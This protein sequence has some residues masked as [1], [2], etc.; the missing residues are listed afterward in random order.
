ME[1]GIS[2][3]KIN[4]LTSLC[5]KN[6]NDFTLDEINEIHEQGK[7]ITFQDVIS[8][9]E[10]L[11][12]HGDIA[13]SFGEDAEEKLVGIVASLYTCDQI[14]DLLSGISY[15]SDIPKFVNFRIEK[16]VEPDYVI[17]YDRLLRLCIDDNKP[18]EILA[19]YNYAYEKLD[20]KIKK[21][22]FEYVYSLKEYNYLSSGREKGVADLLKFGKKYGYDIAKLWPIVGT[23]LLIELCTNEEDEILN[24]FYEIAE[25]KEKY[26][27]D[28]FKRIKDSEIITYELFEEIISNVEDSS[29][30]SSIAEFAV[31]KGYVPPVENFNC[32]IFND[33]S[34][35]KILINKNLVY[36][37]LT[38]NDYSSNYFDKNIYDSLE[39]PELKQI[40]NIIKDYKPGSSYSY[41]SAK[42][43]PRVKDL[44]DVKN[45]HKYFDGEEI[46]YEFL[47]DLTKDLVLDLEVDNSFLLFA[48]D[49]TIDKV[50]TEDKSYYDYLRIILK[51]NNLWW[52][53]V[54][55]EITTAAES[56]EKFAEIMK[57]EETVI[58]FIKNNP[59]YVDITLILVKANLLTEN[60]IKQAYP[61]HAPSS[62][63]LI[64][65]LMDKDCE[66]FD[67][68]RN[69]NCNKNLFDEN[70]PKKDA[71]IKYLLENNYIEETLLLSEKY[72]SKNQN[73][74]IQIAKEYFA[75]NYLEDT[76]KTKELISIINDP[77]QLNSFIVDN[78]PTSKFVDKLFEI[79]AIYCFEGHED[80]LTDKQKLA[81]EV[82]KNISSKELQ[83][84]FCDF[85]ASSSKSILNGDI[86]EDTI[87]KIPELLDLIK[88]SNSSEVSG[89]YIN[90]ARLILQNTNEIKKIH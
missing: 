9:L 70:G 58:Q 12:D 31:K 43:L 1:N 76:E 48:L 49:K 46:K 80:I 72:V 45:I 32:H 37:I 11:D 3:E 71:L 15:Y 79:G 4:L 34:T 75:K 64:K 13:K 23:T 82:Y 67:L 36:Y 6:Y 8:Y 65:E 42:Y 84:V 56:K 21:E 52:G 7:D 83:E 86:P 66:S 19:L 5:Q 47:Q 89:R 62:L 59:Y 87:K 78:K 20:D 14:V 40:F 38:K 54:P 26:L 39:S 53:F 25:E 30:K 27:I 77:E 16:G 17:N 57:N 35:K 61:S 88:L 50:P 44:L 28:S 51:L 18:Y 81:Y 68:F 73:L 29:I 85:I 22:V 24:T 60:I 63:E 41:N 74:F 33:D 69:I 10:Y 55:S 90:I 2:I